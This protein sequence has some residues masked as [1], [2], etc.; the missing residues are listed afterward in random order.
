MPI[1][2][3]WKLEHYLE[4]FACRTI[5]KIF[6]MYKYSLPMLIELRNCSVT[7]IAGKHDHNYDYTNNALCG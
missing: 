6:T 2:F 3:T 4:H 7:Q 5:Y 1:D